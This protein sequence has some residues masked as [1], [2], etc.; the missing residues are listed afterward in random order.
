MEEKIEEKPV[1][2][3]STQIEEKK[4]KKK[5]KVVIIVGICFAVVVVIIVLSVI[6]LLFLRSKKEVH[7]QTTERKP[8][9]DSLYRLNG[10]GLEDFDLYF[11]Q[12]E[13]P[14]KNMIYSPLSI[15]YA[16]AMLNEGTDGDSHDQITSVIGDYQ[17]K[18][19]NNNEHM[20]F[21][22]AMFIRNSFQ[23]N[24]VKDYT[25]NLQNN[26]GAEV[27]YDSFES[28]ANMNSWVSNKTFKLINNLISDDAA[29]EGNFFLINSL[30]IDMNWTTRIQSAS[31]PLPEGMEERYYHVKYYHE[32]YSD[33]IPPIEND[34]YPSMTF[35]GEEGIKS[36]KVGASFNHYDIVNVIGED[37][38]RKTVGEKYQEF[39]DENGM[40]CG[41]LE[42]YLDEYIKAIDSNYSDKDRRDKTS[43][44]FSIYDDDELKLFAKN[45]QNYDGTT[46]QYVAVM[47][48][49][50]SLDSYIKELN[51]ESL[52][53]TIG[54]LK[55]VKYENFK[56]GVVTQIVGNIPLFKFDYQLDLVEDLKTLG[57]K[58]IFDVNKANLSKMVTKE[59]QYIYNA[60]HK[61]NIEFSNDGIKAAAATT[62]GGAGAAGCPFDYLYDVP[63]EKIDITFD[64][65]YL[66][67]IRDVKTGEVWFTGTVYHPEKN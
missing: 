43:T 64:K 60:V 56:D 18:K 22:N 16:L 24:I 31:A 49:V 44:E 5:N 8:V 47:P 41:P 61:A 48:K 11:L 63:V 37:N 53:R 67:L 23:K 66:F 65:P 46:L 1:V 13:N 52:N 28:A 59:K 10:N 34:E 4:P 3:N 6:T 9:A 27:I 30:A 40:D 26:Y 17:A 50:V 15:K 45:L 54:N 39:I 2:E 42:S 25:T 29:K 35:N 51:A 36:V 62:M 58:D 7:T 57:I 55:E 21:A 38:I 20:S 19:Y 14:S 32:K 12:L 33:Y